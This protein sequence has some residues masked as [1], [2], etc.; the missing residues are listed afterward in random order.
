MSRF[1]IQKIQRSPSEWSA[2]AFKQTTENNI[3]W[4]IALGVIVAAVAASAT[5][6]VTGVAIACW[7]IFSAWQ[8]AKEVQRNQTAIRDYGCVAHVLEGDDFRCYYRQV[9][10]QAVEAELTFANQQGYALSETALDYL[11]ERE[12][13][14]SGQAL[15]ASPTVISPQPLVNN[16]LVAVATQSSVHESSNIFDIVSA[17]ASPVQNCVILGVGGSGKGILVSNA[18]RR[19]KADNPNRKIFYVDPKNEE[20]EYGYTN[21][22]VDV[23]KRKTCKNRCPEEICDWLDEVLDEYIQWASQQEESLLV[24]DEGMVIGDACKKTKNTRI[25]TLILHIS[26]LGGAKRENSWLITQ[27]PFVGA[28]GLNLTSSSQMKWV[29]LV[30]GNDLGVIKQW[31]KAAT[32]ENISLDRLGSLISESPVNRAVY[33]GGYSKWYAMPQL[34]NYSAIDRDNNKPN[35]DALSTEERQ[36]LRE[37]EASAT[38]QMIDQLERTRCLDLD[39]FIVHELKAGDRLNEIKGKI[40]R[41]IRQREHYGLVYKFKL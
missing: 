5:S 3:Q 39:E 2:I 7:S 23:V 41:I 15:S 4:K 8:Q 1:D 21:G 35:G 13:V 29:T 19:I 38:Q 9:G 12:N 17:I 18:L 36:L 27:T 16:P 20:G 32:M 11:E 40:I 14:G 24:V 10:E 33:W 37:R 34:A 22:V 30:G 26:S 28:M 31:G 25:G 6:P